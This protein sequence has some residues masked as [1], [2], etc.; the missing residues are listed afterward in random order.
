M[1]LMGEK[2]SWTPPTSEIIRDSPDDSR[3]GVNDSIGWGS[4][5][6]IAEA[7]GCTVG[8]LRVKCSKL[9]ISLRQKTRSRSHPSN[10]LNADDRIVASRDQVSLSLLLP[11]T[12]I[13]LL[14]QRAAAKG[15]SESTLA[16]LLLKIIVCD[17][18]YEAVIDEE[19]CGQDCRR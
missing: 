16:S 19:L 9:G 5:E 4:S 7:I 3:T 12:T 13:D 2:S 15:M 17:D 18:L 11:Q 10:S 14:R 1:R 8:T 6:A